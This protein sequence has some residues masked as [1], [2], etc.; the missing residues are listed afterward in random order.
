MAGLFFYVATAEE[1]NMNKFQIKFAE[2]IEVSAEVKGERLGFATLKMIQA[3]VVIVA[4]TT[5]ACTVVQVF[6]VN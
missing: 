5:V 1:E 2:L 3:A 6:G 4:L